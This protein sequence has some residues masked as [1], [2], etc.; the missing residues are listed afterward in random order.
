MY[1][2]IH[3]HFVNPQNVTRQVDMKQVKETVNNTTTAPTHSTNNTNYN[4]NK[5]KL[6][7][8][9]T[10]IATYH[11]HSPYKKSHQTRE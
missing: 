8:E 9:S 5:Y 1:T 11:T 2:Y 4:K 3:I 6:W 10:R 7:K